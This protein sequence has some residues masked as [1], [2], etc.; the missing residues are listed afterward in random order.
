[1]SAYWN[2]VSFRSHDVSMR[3]K[4]ATLQAAIMSCHMPWCMQSR[5]KSFHQMWQAA[6]AHMHSV[7]STSHVMMCYTRTRMHAPC[8]L[9]LRSSFLAPGTGLET[10]SSTGTTG[11]HMI[12]I[13]LDVNLGAHRLDI[14]VMVDE[15]NWSSSALIASAFVSSASNSAYLYTCK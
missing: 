9:Q 12:H 11:I 3:A 1:M 5:P 8:H 4:L 15:N 6:V 2:T 13:M 10:K 14:S 7:G